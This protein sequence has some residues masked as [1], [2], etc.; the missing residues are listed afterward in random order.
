M[1]QIKKTAARVRAAVV[2]GM[3]KWTR[4]MLGLIQVKYDRTEVV[5]PDRQGLSL[6]TELG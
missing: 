4:G 6:S 1:L 5:L 2:G 3:Y